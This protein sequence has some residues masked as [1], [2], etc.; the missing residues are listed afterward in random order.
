MTRL[1]KTGEKFKMRFKRIAGTDFYGQLLDIPDTSRVSNFLS[2]RR[3]LRVQPNSNVKPC[4]VM[5][6][7]KVK[8]IVA[9]HGDGFFKEP[10][11]RH[12]KLFQ[13]DREYAW[14]QKTFVEDSVTGIKKTVMNPQSTTVYLSFQP[15]NDME[16]SIN[17]PQQTYVAISN[18]YVDRGEQIDD[19]I[20]TKVDEVLGVF[21][22]ELKEK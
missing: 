14:K 1:L 9:E 7:N 4:D 17:I 6:A 19:Y 8:F 11:Y 21:L 22:L 3:Y 10:I 20:V 2:T 16:D 18:L 12:F 13:V 15:K 5:I